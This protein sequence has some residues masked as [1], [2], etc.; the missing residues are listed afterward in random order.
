MDH[1]TATRQATAEAYV[2]GELSEEARDQ[3]EEH[4]FTCPACAAD[5]KVLT[6]LIDDART[7]LAREP[8]SRRITHA[9]KRLFD[10]S[11]RP[12]PALPAAAAVV[13]ALGVAIYQSA[14]TVPDLRH[15]LALAQRPQATSWHFLTV[16]R[17]AP[18]VVLVSPDTRMIGLTLSR[19][20]HEA[21]PYYSVDVRDAGGASATSAV[22]PAPAAGDELQLLLPVSGLAP[23]AYTLVLSGLDERD[24]PATAPDLVRYR[25]TL[26]REETAP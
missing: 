19:S 8:A 13:L 7:V 12:L 21:Y 3:F 16:A 15:E 22:L 18:P 1:A 4:Y 20:G 26:T 11:W 2:L 14:V 9:V 25:F 5:V 6:E 24:G 17:G 10:F 23:G